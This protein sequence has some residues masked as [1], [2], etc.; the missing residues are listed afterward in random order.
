MSVFNVESETTRKCLSGSMKS[1]CL[2]YCRV[3]YFR[4]FDLFIGYGQNDA[5]A[6][7]LFYEKDSL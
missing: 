6:S 2:T 4:S 1:V 5:A 7:G 3:L